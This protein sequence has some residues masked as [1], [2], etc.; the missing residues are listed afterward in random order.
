MLAVQVL[1]QAVV[2]AR[3]V[4][5]E[6]RRR[7]Y[8]ARRV[9]AL[10]KVL[11]RIGEVHRDLHAFIP[12]IRNR[13]EVWVKR[14][15]QHLREIGK[16]LRKVTI[17]ALAEAMPAHDD[18]AAEA[19]ALIRVHHRHRAALACR[20]YIRQDGPTLRIELDDSRLPIYGAYTICN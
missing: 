7:P 8:L 5:K 9:A 12:R 11:M 15:T 6:Q 4:L 16:W 3:S 13:H 10:K 14:R 19:L 1:M 2:V 18:P 17:F 20:Q